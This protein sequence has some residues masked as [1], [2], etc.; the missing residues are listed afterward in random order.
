MDAFEDGQAHAPEKRHSATAHQEVVFAQ[1]RH[2]FAQSVGVAGLRGGAKRY[3]PLRFVS[4]I[5]MQ[6][7]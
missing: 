3:A 1:S 6:P 2:S 5:E 7:I 4:I